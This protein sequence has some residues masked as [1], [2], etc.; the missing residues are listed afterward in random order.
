MFIFQLEYTTLDLPPIKLL[1]NKLEVLV[2]VLIVMVM[3]CK[4]MGR[5]ELR[6]KYIKFSS[7]GG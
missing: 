4:S 7:F 6:V 2:F 5:V 1:I 3:V